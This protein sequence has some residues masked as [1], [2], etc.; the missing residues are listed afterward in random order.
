MDQAQRRTREVVQNPENF[1]DV[2]C[3]WPLTKILCPVLNRL[4]DYSS[5]NDI[6]SE[7][8]GSSKEDVVWE[9]ITLTS[10]MN[11]TRNNNHRVLEEFS[12]LV[13]LTC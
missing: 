9:K 3:T 1:A 12:F 5:I 13:F 2:I 11:G 8:G 4:R 7:R 10:V 6:L